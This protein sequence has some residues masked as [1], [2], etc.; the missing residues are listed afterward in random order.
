MVDRLLTRN[1]LCKLGVVQA[2]EFGQFGLC[3]GGAR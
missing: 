2:D 3:I 1:Q